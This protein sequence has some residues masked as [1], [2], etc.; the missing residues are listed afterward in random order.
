[1]LTLC[2]SVFPGINTFGLLEVVIISIIVQ[3]FSGQSALCPGG[4]MD[5]SFALWLLGW[6]DPGYQTAGFF[7]CLQNR[8]PSAFAWQCRFPGGRKAGYRQTRPKRTTL[9]KCFA[10]QHWPTRDPHETGLAG[11]R[12]SSSSAACL[13]R[14]KP[15]ST[16]TDVPTDTARPLQLPLSSRYAAVWGC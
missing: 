14:G 11:C 6:L 2:F 5:R 15:L 16:V 8:S 13:A 10:L 4:T 9:F 3:V 7:C 12:Q 1:M